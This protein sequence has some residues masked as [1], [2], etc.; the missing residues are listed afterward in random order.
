[1]GLRKSGAGFEVVWYW[2]EVDPLE[3]W[4]WERALLLLGRERE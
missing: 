1:V 2:I 3:M 4:C